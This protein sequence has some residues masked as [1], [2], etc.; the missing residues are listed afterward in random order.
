MR[1]CA[2]IAKVTL[3]TLDPS[4][5]MWLKNVKQMACF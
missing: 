1:S 4:E 2:A 3:K 5:I